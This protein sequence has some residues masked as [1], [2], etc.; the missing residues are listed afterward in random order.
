MVLS[1]EEYFRSNT[2]GCK[3]IM[4][5][6]EIIMGLISSFGERKL[7]EEMW[8]GRKGK[9]VW[10]VRERGVEGKRKGCGR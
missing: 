2:P 7:K 8:K 4:I 3:D 10:K 9:G 1:K 6:N 5:Q